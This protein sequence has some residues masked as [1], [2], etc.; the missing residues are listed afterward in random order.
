MNVMAMP[1]RE[2]SGPAPFGSAAAALATA[3]P[4]L[5]PPRRWTVSEWADLERRVGAVSRTPWRNA[6]TPYM[7]E[8]ADQTLSRRWRG[9]V[10]VGSARSGKTEAL[11][12]NKLGHAVACDPHPMRIIGMDQSSARD[13]V[14]EKINGMILSTPSVRER[15]LPGRSADQDFEKR[16]AGMRLTVRWPVIAHLSQLEFQ[17]I[18]STD[19]DR[20][21]DDIDGE[22]DLWTLMRKR[23][24]TYG[25][26]GMAIAECSPGRPI[27]DETWQ[28]SPLAPHMAPPTTGLLSVYNTGTRGRYYWRCDDCS[29]PFEP[30]V[31]HLRYPAEGTPVA[32]GLAAVMAC[33][34]C[35]SVI[36]PAR[37]R[38]LN[39]AARWLHEAAVPGELVTIDEAV[40]ET[41]VASYWQKGVIAAFMPWSQLV[42]DRIEADAHYERT[43]DETRLVAH[44]NVNEGHP[45]LARG[46]VTGAEL[47]PAALRTKAAPVEMGTAPAWTRFITVAVDTQ[48]NRFVVQ[49]DAW[50]PGLERCL[51]DRFDVHEPPAG[52]PDAAGRAIAPPL[53]AEDWAALRPLLDR[54]YPVAGSAHGLRPAAMVVDSGGEGGTTSNAYAFWRQARKDGIR[55]RCK[56]L[57]GLPGMKREPR[58]IEREPEKV[59]QIRPGRRKGPPAG[60]SPAIVFAAV[61]RLKSEVHAALSRALPGPGAFHLAGG[62]PPQVFDEMC[63]ERETP[64]GFELRAG[65]RRNEGLDLAAYGRAL[66]IVLGAESIDWGNPPGWAAPVEANDWAAGPDDGKAAPVATTVSAGAAPTRE[67][68]SA[69][70]AAP[71]DAGSADDRDVRRPVDRDERGG[72]MS[73][74]RGGWMRR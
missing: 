61:D 16:F 44:V 6:E 34:H 7:V 26:R 60:R 19:Y 20:V 43:G 65:V 32:R 42:A 46:L 27:L 1:R 73:G 37:K 53:Y 39:L 58:A 30:D 72:W 51:I 13:L 4:T 31:Q 15:L 52:A 59:L 68:P 66:A 29:T 11:V 2:G 40:R 9:V 56:I 33:P 8:P 64:D 50:G 62:L 71:A 10:F 48:A 22:G 35:G 57:K 74:R 12:L 67:P 63:A 14:V 28:P 3:L 49:V 54:V 25:S 5:A 17:T 69:D 55:K 23:T 41:D 24:Q 36:E 21:R 70:D 47:S 38:G 45:H 18:L